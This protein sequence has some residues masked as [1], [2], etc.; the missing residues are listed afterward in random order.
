M[1]KLCEYCGKEFKTNKSVQRF[2]S[3]SCGMRSHCKED[4]G[5]FARDD[6]DD[7]VK[8][9]ILGLILS[10]GCIR[11]KDENSTK[12]IC[13][14]SKDKYIL[15]K[16]R[17]IV[18]PNKKIYKDGANGQV[19]WRNQYDIDYLASHGI[20]ERKTKIARLPIVD[21]M[22]HMIRGF[23]D[24]DGCVYNS[25]CHDKKYGRTYTY[26]FISFTIGS[27]RLLS[28]FT[29]FLHNNNIRFSVCKDKRHDMTYCVQISA[30]SSVKYM[31]DKMYF[32]ADSWKLERKYNKF[33][34]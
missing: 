17:D 23:F 2:C 4:L 14:S 11:S 32:E 26:K 29:D 30:K 28:D 3:K 22:W 33:N 6:V 8:K 34:D 19:V 16:I 20:V 9:Y 1:I 10:D 7:R 24:G 31:Y 27:E 18:A 15:E 5:L 13:I 21:N 25:I 12:T